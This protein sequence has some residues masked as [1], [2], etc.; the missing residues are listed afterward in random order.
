MA[1]EITANA[2]QTVA[3][4]KNVLFTETPVPCTKGYVLHR[5]GSGIVTLRGITNQCRA[6]YQ[7]TFGGNIAVPTGETVGEIS[8]AIAL[9]GEPL[10]TTTMTVTPAAVE[11]FF[12]VSRTTFIDVPRGCCLTVSVENVSTIPVN[13]ENASL[14]VE[15]VA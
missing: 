15:R 3:V 14:V 8:L 4:N 10:Q 12:N 2:L 5:E 7:I 1:Y 13:V 11:E 9:D 6:R